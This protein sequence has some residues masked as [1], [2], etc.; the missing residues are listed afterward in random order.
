M[1]QTQ[2][3][4][5]TVDDLNALIDIEQ[6]C[7]LIGQIKRRQLRYLLTRAKAQ[8]WG[9]FLDDVFVGYA[10]YLT[11][12]IPRRARLY[13]LAVLPAFRR[14]KIASSLLA[15]GQFL[16]ASLGYPALALEV[17]CSNRAAL[18]LYQRNGF[19]WTHLLCEY[20]PDDED[21]WKMVC[22]LP[23]PLWAESFSSTAA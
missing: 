20:Y 3:R 5:V 9:A 19:R 8:V 12:N 11:P 18:T 15:H 7:F 16:M 1:M 10:I 4:R 22:P 6:N 23:V 17:R 13:A 21:G 2:I 14:Q